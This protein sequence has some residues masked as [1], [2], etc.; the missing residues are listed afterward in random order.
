MPRIVKS[1]I[2]NQYGR[3]FE[4]EEP[5]PQELR[6]AR[7]RALVNEAISLG[8]TIP[9]QGHYSRDLNSGDPV[10]N[11]HSKLSDEMLALSWSLHRKRFLRDKGLPLD[12]IQSI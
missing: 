5:T 2:L 12:L 3:S 6:E 10:W 11:E 1:K 4:H 9:G 7:E 8:Y